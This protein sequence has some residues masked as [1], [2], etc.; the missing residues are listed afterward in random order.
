V[1][2]WLALMAPCAPTAYEQ[3]RPVILIDTNDSEH[4]RRLAGLHPVAEQRYRQTL[5][6]IPPAP[7]ITRVADGTRRPR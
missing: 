2:G 3:P 6:Q 4:F 1:C 7:K 5:G